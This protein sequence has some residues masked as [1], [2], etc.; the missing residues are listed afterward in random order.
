MVSATGS[1]SGQA[2][3]LACTTDE[4]QPIVHSDPT[5]AQHAG[6]Q[7]A[8][9]EPTTHSDLKPAQSDVARVL[10][11]QGSAGHEGSPKSL[12]KLWKRVSAPCCRYHRDHHPDIMALMKVNVSCMLLQIGSMVWTGDSPSPRGLFG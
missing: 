2:H 1:L 3:Q 5:P 6:P 10:E 12:S 4:K 7:P 8:E 11:P 9:M